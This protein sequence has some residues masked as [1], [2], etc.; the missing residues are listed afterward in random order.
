MLLSVKAVFIFIL[1]R[2]SL[3]GLLILSIHDYSD[4]QI[5][6]LV[7]SA[8]AGTIW[9]SAISVNGPV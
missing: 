2:N 9:P 1:L 7:V 6:F 3:L 8:R 5:F 4:I